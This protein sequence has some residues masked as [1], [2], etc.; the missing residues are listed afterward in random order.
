MLCMAVACLRAG[1]FTPTIIKNTPEK[2]TIIAVIGLGYVGLPLAIEFGKKYKTLGFDLS[3]QKIAAYRDHTDPTGEV[4]REAFQEAKQL[5]CHT[6]PNVI[7]QAHFI[8][9]AVP[10]PVDAAHQPDLKPLQ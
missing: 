10:T 7:A 8:V 4:P 3:K 1:N 6:D 5:T 9:V 2:M